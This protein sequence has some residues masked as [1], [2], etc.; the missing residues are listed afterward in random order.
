[1]TRRTERGEDG[2][3]LLMALIFLTVGAILTAALLSF[4]D[5]DFRTTVNVREQGKVLYAT[6]AAMEA[7]INA[8]RNGTACGSLPAAP[9]V[10]GVSGV[11]VTCTEEV[12]SGGGGGNQPEFAVI[13]LATGAED[14][15]RV[16]SGAF[17]RVKGGV[18]SNSTVNVSNSAQLEVIGALTATACGPGPITGASPRTCDSTTDYPDPGPPPTAGTKFNPA[19]TTATTMT[20]RSMPACPALGTPVEFQ[21]GAYLSGDALTTFF[22]S[23]G[24]GPS[25][26]VF[27]FTPGVYYF[28]FADADPDDHVWKI[29]H[30]TDIVLGGTPVGLLTD[31]STLPVGSRCDASATAGVQFIFGEDSRI[32]VDSGS[33]E[34]CAS[35]D[36]TNTAQEIA[37]YGLKTSESIP[38][39]PTPQTTTY[40]AATAT[41]SP[42]TQFI[43]ADEAKTVG[44][45]AAIANLVST[46]NATRAAILNL[47]GFSAAAIPPDSTI[48]S[49]V[50]KVTHRETTTGNINHLD[51]SAAVTGGDGATTSFQAPT[52]ITR[53]NSATTYV[54]DTLTLPAAFRTISQLTGLSV[55]YTASTALTNTN[56][57]RSFSALLDAVVLEVNYTPPSPPPTAYL[58]AQSGCVTLQAP[59]TKYGDAGT[60]ALISTGGSAADVSIR[61]TVYAPLAA[62]D[63]HLVSATHQV[64]GRGV[65]V[66]HLTSNVTSSFS[67][68]GD[69]CYPFQLPAPSVAVGD[70][71]FI[72]TLDGKTR[73]RALV[74]FN[75]AA[76]P[77]VKSW[78]V[79]NE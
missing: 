29:Q 28:D 3:I 53:N 9:T 22:D 4:A 23:C 5:T 61:G 6:D 17:S 35:H 59:A 69:S 8:Y 62:L 37:V 27:Y 20:I 54:T 2:A 79:V 72:A 73:L 57:A 43:P 74:R 49:A 10:N 16:G 13:A 67:C 77:T 26:R 1:M 25:P 75:G 60:C 52:S 38:S 64:F 45:A 36:P 30:P 48:N 34:L 44:G 21:P 41:P 19:V 55:D 18:Y 14:S 76:A 56:N 47:G 32:R 40:N 68:V 50:L 51:L 7:A 15:V 58:R 63:I 31:V 42:S 66:R 65:I 33:L 78:S 12:V 70:V 71:V 11:S 39:P 24:G 46:A